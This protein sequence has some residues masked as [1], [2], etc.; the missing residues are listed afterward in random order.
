M[1]INPLPALAFVGTPFAL[2]GPSTIP[3]LFAS[4][5]LASLTSLRPS[6]SESK[7]K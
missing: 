6:P 4:V 7:S 3:S 2:I 1:L 5:P